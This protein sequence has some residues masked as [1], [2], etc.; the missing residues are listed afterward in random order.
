MLMYV[1]RIGECLGFFQ[2]SPIRI[3][4]LNHIPGCAV[5]SLTLELLRFDFIIHINL[6]GSTHPIQTQTCYKDP[7]NQL[8]P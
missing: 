3:G 6:P 1:Q 5:D 7:L 2:Y 8:S 4:Y